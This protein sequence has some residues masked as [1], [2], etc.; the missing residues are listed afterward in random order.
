M[1]KPGQGFLT[2]AKIPEQLPPWLTE[3]DITYLVE[4]YKRSGYRG[5]LN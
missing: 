4:T 5:G 2:E 1:M 3:A